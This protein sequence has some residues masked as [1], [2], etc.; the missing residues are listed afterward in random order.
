MNEMMPFDGDL[1][2][3]STPA[4]SISPEY[5]MP[6]SMGSGASP[7]EIQ[8]QE[9]YP[10]IYSSM[11][12]IVKTVIDEWINQNPWKLQVTEVDI[13]S[14]VKLVVE[15]AGFDNEEMQDEA[16]GVFAPR[17]GSGSFGGRGRRGGSIPFRDLARIL[18]IQQLLNRRNPYHYPCNPYDPYCPYYRY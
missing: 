14:M 10:E 4:M 12:P 3:M 8:L 18:L 1:Q 2:M 9:M 6:E 11:Y 16:V 17:G 13:A 15:A 7:H 5:M